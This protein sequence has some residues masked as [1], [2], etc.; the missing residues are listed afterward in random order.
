MVLSKAVV[1]RRFKKRQREQDKILAQFNCVP[2]YRENHKQIK[3]HLTAIYELLEEKKKIE[4]DNQAEISFIDPDKMH[5]DLE[6]NIK[7]MLK[8]F[9]PKIGQ[10][11]KGLS[12][13]PN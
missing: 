2:A 12:Q 10:T 5:K 3:D 11:S 1:V 9:F 13:S 4:K 8:D 6:N 7:F